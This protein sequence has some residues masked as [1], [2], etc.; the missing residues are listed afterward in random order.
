M[1]LTE[2]RAACRHWR[3]TGLRECGV[4]T[5]LTF[6][7]GYVKCGVGLQFHM[8][9]QQ[10]SCR[11]GGI[12]PLIP[13]LSITWKCGDLHAP[14]DQPTLPFSLLLLLLGLLPKILLMLPIPT[15]KTST[16][17]S[18]KTRSGG[19]SSKCCC[20]VSNDTNDDNLSGLVEVLMM[21]IV[22]FKVVCTVHHVST[23]R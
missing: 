8:L 18:T 15:N 5:N 2:L 9:R 6:C 17:I 23:S 21:M 3:G 14:A 4:A 16:I 11:N 1:S 22:M 20:S 12:H 7:L 10:S 13:K 19:N